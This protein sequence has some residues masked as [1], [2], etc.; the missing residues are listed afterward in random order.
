MVIQLPSAHGGLDPSD[1]QSIRRSVLG[2]AGSLL[3]TFPIIRELHIV[4]AGPAVSS[5]GRAVGGFVN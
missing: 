1:V 3:E 5:G 4:T 2:V